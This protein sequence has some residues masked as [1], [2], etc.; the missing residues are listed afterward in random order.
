M[1]RRPA[2]G[3]AV[4]LAL[5]AA[6]LAVVVAREASAGDAA[7]PPCPVAPASATC[8]PRWRVQATGVATF[9]PAVDLEDDRGDVAVRRGGFDVLTTYEVSPRWTVGFDLGAE[10]STYDFSD[11]ARLVPGA[12]RLFEEGTTVY[13]A[14][15]LKLTL[16]DTWAFAG[17]VTV[18]TGFA[19]GADASDGTT[20]SVVATVRR[21][22][23][24][25]LAVLVGGLYSTSLE[26]DPTIVPIVTIMG[27]G[28]S[29]GPV[30]FEFRGA[31]LRA[32][33]A[34]SERVAVAASARY[35]RREFRLAATDRVPEGVFRDVRVP[36]SLEL[37]LRPR[38]NVT[39][40]G[41]VGVNAYADLRFDDRDGN[42]LV[43]A[44]ADVGLWFGLSATIR[45]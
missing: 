20:A 25:S 6:L 16:D 43:D 10:R 21:R 35:V 28:P 13:V 33:Y 8:A 9:S 2:R 40:S 34:L 31:G 15:G 19:P 38:P 41:A 18:S 32:T 27:A 22:V 45:F 17:A 30:R 37:D 39:I 14:P 44:Q 42:E 11:P 12:G 5:L 26:D 1:S 23:S 3:A 7:R 29:E 36:V 24:S 4:P